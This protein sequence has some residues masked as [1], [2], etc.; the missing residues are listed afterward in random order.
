MCF[1]I[2]GISSYYLWR[3]FLHMSFLDSLNNDGIVFTVKKLVNNFKHAF[4]SL[5]EVILRVMEAKGIL[6]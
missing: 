2:Y 6:F 3:L 5:L 1:D 4:L